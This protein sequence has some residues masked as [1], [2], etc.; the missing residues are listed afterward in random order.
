[1]YVKSEDVTNDEE[2][3]VEPEETKAEIREQSRR[4]SK[5]PNRL[6]GY[7]IQKTLEKGYV[8]ILS[9]MN[10]NMADNL[11]NKIIKMFDTFRIF[12][13]YQENIN[14]SCHN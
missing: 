2:R 9:F 1:M 10:Y 7:R 8:M 5:R 4:I 11:V 13:Y 12:S 3:N 6:E 14:F